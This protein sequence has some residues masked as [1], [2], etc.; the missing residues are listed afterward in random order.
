MLPGT[1]A[2]GSSAIPFAGYSHAISALVGAKSI[3]I[4]SVFEGFERLSRAIN[5]RS[6]FSHAKL[7]LTAA[8][9]H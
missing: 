6:R 5:Q 9:Q 8:L 2:Q 4:R 1:A 7:T 3:Y